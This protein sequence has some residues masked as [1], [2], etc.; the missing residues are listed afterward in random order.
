VFAYDGDLAERYP[1][2]RAGLVHATG[3][4]NGPSPPALLEAYRAEQQGAVERLSATAL[5]DLPSIVAWR[6][7][8][9]A[10]GAKPTQYRNAAEALLRRLDKH[11]DIPSIST[12]VDLGNLVS[13]RYAM[14]VAVFDRAG[15]AGSITVRFARG[16]EPF[17]D[18]GSTEVT[19][20]EPGEVVFVDEEDVVCARR[21]CWRQS[22]QSA[23]GAA[24]TEALI[25]VEGQHETAGRDV[26]AAVG[27]LAALLAAHQPESRARVLA[28]GHAVVIRA[29]VPT[30]ASAVAEI[31]R[32]GW[33]DGH[34]GLVPQELVEL[35]T[36]ESFG[37]RAA[38]RVHHTTVA[39]VDGSV[40]GFV[41]VVED[42]VEQVYVAAAH[43]GS[44]VA[45]A[46]IAEAERQVKAH[47]HDKAWLAV[48]AGNGRARAFYE[49][50]GWDDEGRFDYAA[51]TERGPIAVP[52]HRYTKAV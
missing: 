27:D 39:T 47:G 15:V 40:A 26:R 52:C 35:R 10:F 45:Q 22:A 49:R 48:V 36:D 1:G 5:A 12:L 23:T 17:T 2:I 19:R 30:D 14:P 43:R 38:K 46:L 33:R 42:E 8:F 31:W 24:T 21:W 9:T 3:L 44:G 34:E 28:E 11:G 18:L 51:A 50:A 32:L 4:A 41:M 6:R 20:P 7:A 25:V 29:A 13:I 16:D 37:T